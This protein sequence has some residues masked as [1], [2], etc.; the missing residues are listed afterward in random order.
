MT[1]AKAGYHKR[2]HGCVVTHSRT[3]SAHYYFIIASMLIAFPTKASS[4]RSITNVRTIAA[5]RIADA[6][7]VV[8]SP[9]PP[10]PSFLPRS[11][12]GSFG[13]VR[14]GIGGSPHRSVHIPRLTKLDAAAE[15][16]EFPLTPDDDGFVQ[17]ASVSG[18]VYSQAECANAGGGGAS[19]E[20]GTELTVRL[21]T[22]EGCTLCDKVKE[23]GRSTFVAY[24]IRCRSFPEH[25]GFGEARVTDGT[26]RF[27]LDAYLSE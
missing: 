16:H 23:V 9:R 6:A 20:G 22:K 26:H 8:G 10:P 11:K 3:T 24:L 12:R 14:G 17:Q 21:F 18:V 27:I 4:L 15:G 25:F 7:F 2:K 1:E 13:A 19:G 5:G